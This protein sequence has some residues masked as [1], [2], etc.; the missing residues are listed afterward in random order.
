MPNMPISTPYLYPVNVTVA[1]QN[2]LSDLS[3]LIKTALGILI[4]ILPLV[5]LII[6]LIFVYK[7]NINAERTYRLLTKVFEEENFEAKVKNLKGIFEP[8]DKADKDRK[9][10]E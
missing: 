2:L 10:N 4:I 7:I 6:I 9:N 8:I 3:K 5:I 1:V